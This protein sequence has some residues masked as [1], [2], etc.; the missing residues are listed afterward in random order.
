[1]CTNRHI[2]K[3]I[4]IVTQHFPPANI[5]GAFRPYRLAKSL[6]LRG[7]SCDVITTRPRLNYSLDWKL[8]GLLKNHVK[9]KY[10]YRSSVFAKKNSSFS[11]AENN[12]RTAPRLNILTKLIRRIRG[13]I[14]ELADR[15]IHPD[16]HLIHCPA[17]IAKSIISIRNRRPKVA[18]TTSPPH[19]IH[20]V[21]LIIKRIF[22]IP[23]VVDF[24]DP[25]DDFPINGNTDVTRSIDRY[26]K[27]LIITQ[28]DVVI[29][30]TPTYTN[31]ILDLD[32]IKVRDKFHTVT[33][34]YEKKL[35]DQTAKK[36][37]DYFVISYLGIFYP[38]K[39]PFTFFRAIRTWLDN[40]TAQKRSWILN[41][42]RVQLIGSKNAPTK[43][44]IDSLSLNE[45]VKF[46]DR[47]PHEEAVRILKGSDMALIATGLKKQTRPGWLPSKLFEYLGCRI[48]ILAI[49][50]DGE[51]ADVIKETNSGY[52][53]TSE[54]HRAIVKIISNELESKFGIDSKTKSNFTFSNIDRFSE[55][56]VMEQMA[57]II[58]SA[59]ENSV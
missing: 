29:S 56:N 47:V 46:V 58:Q 6:I 43:Q 10:I 57:R 3:N 4:L 20:I 25:W 16:A 21:G 19:S 18:I 59:A 42:L 36:S 22:N 17:Y 55:E 48:P 9:I 49:V 32:Y 13:T 24:R 51:V 34:C 15:F 30:S 33:N 2:S 53:I 35:V 14:F 7:Y 38:E 23:W 27:R 50:P 12:E 52:A 37:K 11:I 44:V 41:H 8:L 1:M 54:N 39:D 40:V 5:V 28:A 26:L 45:I 31:N